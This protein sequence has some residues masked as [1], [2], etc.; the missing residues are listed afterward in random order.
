VRQYGEQFQHSPKRK[1]ARCSPRPP[2]LL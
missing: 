1:P 2:K